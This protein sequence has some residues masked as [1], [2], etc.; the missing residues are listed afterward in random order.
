MDLRDQ[1][2]ATLGDAYKIERELGGGGMSRVFVAEERRF[3]RQVVIKVLSPD[4][5]AGLSADRFEREITVAAQLQHPHVVP[6][7]NAGE[8]QGLPFYTMPFV[9]GESLRARLGRGPMSIAESVTVLRDVTKALVYAHERGLVHRDIKP[10]NILLSGGSAVVTDFGIAKALS[11]ARTNAG[12]ATITQLG[13]SIGT[14]AY[15]SPEQAAGDPD[16]DSRADLYAL[17]CTAYEMLSGQIP[18]ANRTAQRILAA[19][20][21]EVPRD[22]RELR[23]DC[24]P[25]LAELVMQC[26]AKDPAARPQHAADVLSVLDSASTSGTG[27]AMPSFI[28]APGMMRKALILY[29]IAFLV[30]AFI[31]KAAVVATGVPDWVF[32]GALVVMALGF[33]VLLFTGFV[34]RVARHAITKT[35]TLTPGGT[36]APHSTMVDLALKASPHVTLHRAARWGVYTLASFALV[37]IVFMSLR[38]LG[39]G[40]WGTLLAAG[41]LE[42]APLMVADFHATGDTALGT[43]VTEAVRSDLAQS[44]A[45][46]LLAPDQVT[47]ALRR[48]RRTDTRIDLALARELAQR[49]GVGAVVDGSVQQVGGSYILTLRLVSADS[50]RE[51]ASYHETAATGAELIPTLG[52]MT[53]K[54]RARIGESLKSVRDAPPLEVATTA[55]LPALRKFT[56][57]VTA[58]RL[59]DTPRAIALLKEAIAIDT[60]FATAYARLSGWADDAALGQWAAQQAFVRRDR[61]NEL[62]RA[63]V[64]VAYYTYGPPATLNTAK[65]LQ[66]SEERV[67]LAPNDWIAVHNLASAALAVGDLNRA[68]SLMRR[69]QQMAPTNPFPPRNRLNGLRAAGAPSRSI[70]S[71]EDVLI[72][73]APSETE[74]AMVRSDRYTRRGAYDSA[75]TILRAACSSERLA[76]MRENC[77][78]AQADLALLQGR[79]REFETSM[80][81]AEAIARARGN[82][83]AAMR[84]ALFIAMPRAKL[85]GDRTGALRV[86]DSVQARYPLSTITEANRP[87]SDLALGYAMAGKPDRGKPFLAAFERRWAGAVEP[88]LERILKDVRAQFALYSGDGAGALRAFRE[89]DTLCTYCHDFPYWMHHNPHALLAEAHDLIGNA[90]SALV[91]YRQFVERTRSVTDNA[92]LSLALAYKRIGELS[93]QKGDAAAAVAAYERFVQ[94]WKDA[95]PELQPQVTEVRLR[96]RRLRERDAARH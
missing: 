55:S 91:Q 82:P 27:P 44:R 20:M 90:D 49:E 67:R 39:I 87:Y 30:V 26:L 88:A 75:S 81:A 61:L 92:T 94:L 5:A 4:L 23:T 70:D 57:A 12:G 73:V 50:G 36:R 62:E 84:N 46:T 24:P 43:V 17:G 15:M 6:V 9:Q 37:V 2:Q 60:G 78:V 32:P 34:Q 13:T 7:L 19:H 69:A 10:D 21:T 77:V 52:A 56:E 31:A 89:P 41:T 96:L 85:L 86:L 80:R 29:V 74:K 79:L 28:G 58:R 38:V 25:V 3:G 11:A 71:A 1:L 22:I 65:A 33:P 40:P 64:D 72:G 93:E 42:R 54:L 18:F 95:D 83:S 76:D 48:M 8:S 53:K 59:N 35:P 45:V 47:A 14:P 63:I 66:A 68:D 51:L 16:V